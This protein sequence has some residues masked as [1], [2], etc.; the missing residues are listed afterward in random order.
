[1]PDT[2]V[3]TLNPK[4]ITILSVLYLHDTFFLYYTY[5]IHV[6]ATLAYHNFLAAL[7]VG[8]ALKV[9]HFYIYSAFKN[10]S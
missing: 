10:Q 8:H 9:Q 1:M 6:R 2:Y 7:L 4:S 5:M 3:I